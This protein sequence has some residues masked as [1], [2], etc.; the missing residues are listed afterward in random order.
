M[1]KYAIGVRCLRSFDVQKLTDVSRLDLMLLKVLKED[2]E[3]LDVNSVAQWHFAFFPETC[4]KEQIADAL[5]DLA[6]AIDDY[7]EVYEEA[8]DK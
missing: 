3:L 1:D 5:R 2:A 7:E 4:T 8:L 6:R